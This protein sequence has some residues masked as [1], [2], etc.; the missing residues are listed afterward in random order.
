MSKRNSD[1]YMPSD[2]RWILGLQFGVP[3]VA[4][5]AGLLL[6]FV[7]R[8]KTADVR[9]LY[10]VGLAAGIIG[11]ALLFLARLPLY[12]ERE[13]WTAGPKDLDRKHRR[14]YWMAYVF[15]AASLTLLGGVLLRLHEN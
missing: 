14:I 15:V 5:L 10:G 2:W 12:K 4:V 13:F 9:A 8:L 7:A 6:P 1:W 3:C 11:V